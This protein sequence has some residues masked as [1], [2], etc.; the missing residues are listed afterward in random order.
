M[1]RAR[2]AALLAFGLLVRL[3]GLWQ[4]G[5]Y[6]TEVQKAWAFR[7]ADA[8]VRDIY[9]PPD[10][11]LLARARAYGHAPLERFPRTEF[12]WQGAKY[13]V[14][15]PPGSVLVLWAAGKL[16]SLVHEEMPNRAGFNA[17]IN[18]APLL[19]SVAIA[20]M[21]GR[22]APGY[23]GLRRALLF[24]LNPAVLLAVPYLGYQDTIF[25]AF[26]LAALLALVERRYAWAAALVVAAGLFK[27]QG[28]LLLPTLA[29]VT[30]RESPLRTWLRCLL[31]GVAVAALILLPWWSQGYLLSAL[32]G[33]RRP[34]TQTTLAPLGLNAWWIAGYALTRATQGGWPLAPIVSIDAFQAWAGLDPRL[35]AR[36]LLL[37]ATLINMVLLARAPHEDRRFIP[38]S[39]VLQVHAYALLATSVHENHTFLAVM[40]LPLLVGVWPHA[41]RALALTSAF[42]FASLFFAAGFGRHVTRLRFVEAVKLSTVVDLSVIVAALHVVLVVLLFAWVARTRPEAGP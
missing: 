22:S 6:D 35:V 41:L 33:C 25:G 38:L 34:L 31:A 32:D 14:D 17:A 26:A 5:T 16:W 40:L 21:L 30:L 27:P 7:A 11:A 36:V 18:L 8:G 37:F 9:G 24:W 19:A 15:Y 42:L 28:A 4:W 39:V 3:A 10:G 29:V 13:F 12:E 20:W 1:S 23:P 2:L